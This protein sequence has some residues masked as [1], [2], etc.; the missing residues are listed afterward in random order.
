MG[1]NEENVERRRMSRTQEEDE[2]LQNG[3]R[4]V[5]RNTPCQQLDQVAALQDDEGITSLP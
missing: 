2:D 5:H 1:E 4:M 3:N